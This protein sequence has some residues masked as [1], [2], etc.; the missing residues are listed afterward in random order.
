V[1]GWIIRPATERTEHEQTDLTRILDRCQTPQTVDR[2]VGDVA[3]MLRERRGR[4][5]DT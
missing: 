2:P 1:T 5:L 4:H 3:G